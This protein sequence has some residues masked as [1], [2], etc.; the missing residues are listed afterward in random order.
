MPKGRNKE[1]IDRRN[2]ALCRRWY[3]WTEMES[4]CDLIFCSWDR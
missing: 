1:L 4:E 3:Y 2:E